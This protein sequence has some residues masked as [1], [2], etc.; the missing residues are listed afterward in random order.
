MSRGGLSVVGQIARAAELRIEPEG[1]R[2]Q[3]SRCRI[4]AADEERFGVGAP[5]FGPLWRHFGGPPELR[6]RF[7]EALRF[8]QPASLPVERRRLGLVGAL[9]GGHA[10]VARLLRVAR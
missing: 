3:G 4:V 10:V 7:G 2:V 6:Q 8:V 9:V 5:G 1:P